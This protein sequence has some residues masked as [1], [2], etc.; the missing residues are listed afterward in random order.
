MIMSGTDNHLTGVGAMIEY[1]QQA[2]GAEKYGGRAG[3][4]GYM[5][6]DVACIAEIL[7]DNGYY[8]AHGGKVS[9]TC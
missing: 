8:T 1:K 9:N 3:Y 2:K 7:G 6:K 5:N 4:D